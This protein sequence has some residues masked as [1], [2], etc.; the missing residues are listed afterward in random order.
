MTFGS[1]N[2]FSKM[3]D[4]VLE[5]ACD[6]PQEAMDEIAK[7]PLVKEV[8]LFGNGLH[9]VARDAE[10]AIPALRGALAAKGLALSRLERIQPSLEDVFVSL[11]E[12]SDRDAE[13]QAE[14]AR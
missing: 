13:A 6:R 14:V 4:E 2:T 8:A 1:F 3:T 5:L 12:A 11:I 9:I 7:L 10:A